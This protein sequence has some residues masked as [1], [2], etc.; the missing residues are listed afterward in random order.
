MVFHSGVDNAFPRRVWE[1]PKT[2]IISFSFASNL[3]LSSKCLYLPGP[4]LGIT[5]SAQRA[6]LVTFCFHYLDLT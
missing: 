5:I 6:P 1:H 2:P 3:D 4:A